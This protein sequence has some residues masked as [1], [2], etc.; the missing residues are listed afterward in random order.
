MDA[1][2]H[3]L[4]ASWTHGFIHNLIRYLGGPPAPAVA[5]IDTSHE[6]L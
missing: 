6:W 4:T 3:R 1:W 2:I 5:A